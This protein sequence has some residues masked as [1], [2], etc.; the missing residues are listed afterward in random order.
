MKHI[1]T[2][3][4]HSFVDLITNS[5]SELFVCNGRKTIEAIKTI[6][7]TLLKN[8]DSM[9]GTQHSFDGVFGTIEESKYKFQWWLVSE[10]V[11]DEYV[12]YHRYTSYGT[13]S[14]LGISSHSESNEERL[15]DEQEREIG[16]KINIHE[17][18]L[19]ETNKKEYN[20]RW[21]KYRKEVDRIGSEFGYCALISEG[22]LF[23][24][25]L[26]QNDFSDK[27]INTVS[28]CFSKQANIHL[29]DLHGRYPTTHKVQ[30]SKKFLQVF[31]AFQQLERWGI[32]CN[33]GDVFV[34]STGD[35]TIP[36]ELMDTICAYLSAERH[37]LG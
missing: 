17:E 4:T 5:S 12:R 36:Y 28:K 31:E 29:K 30:L 25:F 6:L 34:Y 24:E 35:N 19:F 10:K 20:R 1:L 21:K 22:N 14:C 32:S 16:K 9:M 26:R 8:H 18:D 2:I 11:R 15:L 37:H 13:H 23:N 27:D 3:S 7:D 33:K